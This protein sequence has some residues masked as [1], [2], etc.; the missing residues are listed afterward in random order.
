M[1]NCIGQNLAMLELR[2][3]LLLLLA[4]FDMQLAP[5]AGGEEG[6]RNRMQVGWGL[7]L[8]QVGAVRI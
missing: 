4:A 6:V 7:C 2:S 1:R 3:C 5:E 8:V